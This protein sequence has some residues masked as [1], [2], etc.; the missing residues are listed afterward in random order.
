MTA[1]RCFG[2]LRKAISSLEQCYKE[3]ISATTDPRAAPHGQYPYPCSYTHLGLEYQFTYTGQLDETKLLYSAKT[4]DNKVICIK[5]VRRYSTDAHEYCATKGFAPELRGFRYL[6]G[7]WRM[8]VMDMISQEYRC[9]DL[10][11]PYPHFEEIKKELGD[12][13]QKGL[14]HGDVR[15]VNIMVK[16]DNSPGFKLVDFDWSGTIGIVKYPINV[17]RKNLWRP[18]GAD[19][20]KEITAGHDMEMLDYMIKIQKGL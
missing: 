18:H 7:G 9:L 17:N 14:V 11:V 3:M 19:D 4:T 12:L 1:A 15:D 20:E 5:F 2:A 8:V 13:H 16:V 10:N 6:P